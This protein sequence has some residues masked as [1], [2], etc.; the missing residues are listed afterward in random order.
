MVAH[1]QDDEQIAEWCW[2]IPMQVCIAFTCASTPASGSA[3]WNR[4][5]LPPGGLKRRSWE[6]A[7]LGNLGI[8]YKSLGEYRRAIEYHEQD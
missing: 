8:A 7:A 4:L 5:W 6:G 2:S 1:Q 3:G